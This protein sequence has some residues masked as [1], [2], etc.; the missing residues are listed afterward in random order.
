VEG[1]APADT[2]CDSAESHVHVAI[3][4]HAAD[5]ATKFHRQFRCMATEEFD[6]IVNKANGP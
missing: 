6:A 3:H 4:Q 1:F 5:D 2:K